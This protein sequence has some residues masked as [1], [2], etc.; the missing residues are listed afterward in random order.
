[1]IQLWNMARIECEHRFSITPAVRTA[2]AECW[3]TGGLATCGDISIDPTYAEELFANLGTSSIALNFW[4]IELRQ[5]G[6]S[7]TLENGESIR[8]D[9]ISN[10]LEREVL[11]KLAGSY[12]S[13]W[14]L[15]KNNDFL[16]KRSGEKTEEKFQ[17]LS[18]SIC[19][20]KGG[21]LLVSG[22]NKER[23]EIPLKCLAKDSFSSDY[24]IN[25]ISGKKV[26]H[27]VLKLLNGQ[28]QLSLVTSQDLPAKIENPKFF[29][30]IDLGAG[31]IAITDF[32]GS[33]YSI[34]TR[35]SDKFW[36]NRITKVEKRQKKRVKDS[37]GWNR[38]A[39]ARKYMH[40]RSHEQKK[41]HQRKLADAL[42]SGV[43]CIIIGKSKNRLGLSRT[44][45]G[46]SDQH[47]GVQNT[48]YMFRQFLYIKEKAEE[49][50]IS[51]ILLPDPQRKGSID[52]P[53]SKF[54]ASREMLKKVLRERGLPVPIEF[55]RKEFKIDFGQGVKHPHYVGGRQNV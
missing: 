10:D 7:I 17:T 41:S 29:R 45:K 33:E 31:N 53:E 5:N 37:R 47:Y 14:K 12:S 44:K 54:L 21:V 6:V 15:K 13:F 16:A 49:R 34:P 40:N 28:F 36:M 1:M 27:A 51:V 32:D 18:W 39:K 9:S 52:D 20:I 38:L 43:E 30:A 42:V 22:H 11:R 26:V 55:K 25:N 35:R 8:L 48:G 50:G 23:L 46:T 19:S 4:L 3:E 24:L 2:F